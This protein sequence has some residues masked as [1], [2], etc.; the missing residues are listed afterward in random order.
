MSRLRRLKRLVGLRQSLHRVAENELM[1]ARQDKRIA[2][3]S[4]TAVKRAVFESE[5][6]QKGHV[7]GWVQSITET[8]MSFLDV[9]EGRITECVRLE[10]AR[11]K[12]RKQMERLFE[13]L[14]QRDLIQKKR[15]EQKRMDDWVAAKWGRRQ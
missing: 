5:D 8:N 10:K 4:I 14:E 1:V 2:E 11:F 12:E 9:V 15:S 7:E 6:D 13:R 3:D